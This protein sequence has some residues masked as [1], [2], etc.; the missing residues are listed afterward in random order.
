MCARS[1]ARHASRPVGGSARR[2]LHDRWRGRQGFVEQQHLASVASA[3]AISS[4]RSPCERLAHASARSSSPTAANNDQATGVD[5]LDRICVRHRS[6]WWGARACHYTFKRCRLRNTLRIWKSATWDGVDAQ[7]LRVSRPSNAIWPASAQSRPVGML[8]RRRF[9]APSADQ[10][11][12][13]MDALRVRPQPPPASQMLVKSRTVERLIIYMVR[14]LDI[15]EWRDARSRRN[16]ARTSVR[17][18]SAQQPLHRALH[19]LG[20]AEPTG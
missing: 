1:A 18:L 11:V 9:A 7:R 13:P 15:T 16:A 20:T 12:Q 14:L 3:M 8:K 2:P 17:L 6:F 5:V 19:P 4:R 10:A